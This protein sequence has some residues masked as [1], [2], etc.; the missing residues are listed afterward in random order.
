MLRMAETGAR[1]SNSGLQIAAAEGRGGEAGQ[2]VARTPGRETAGAVTLVGRDLELADLAQVHVEAA[3]VPPRDHTAH[4]LCSGG[5]PGDSS[6]PN[7]EMR[8]YSIKLPYTLAKC[9]VR[10]VS[11]NVIKKTPKK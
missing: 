4:A 7:Q 5:I 6:Q 8:R 10:K 9:C 3:L 1:R 11:R 2:Q